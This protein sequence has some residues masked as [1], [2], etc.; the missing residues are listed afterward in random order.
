MI[1][2]VFGSS[3]ERSDWKKQK[4]WPSNVTKSL[5]DQTAA[6][7]KFQRTTDRRKINF[8]PAV[9]LPSGLRIKDENLSMKGE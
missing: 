1:I 3:L 5:N 8:N 2:S 4:S 6:Y 7:R 9:T